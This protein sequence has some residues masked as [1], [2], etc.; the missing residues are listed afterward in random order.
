MTHNLA[1]PIRSDRP[2]FG[3]GVAFALLVG[4]AHL[5]ADWPQFRGPEGTG[6]TETR[7]VPL[8][9]SET[10]NVT[11]RTA[12]HG[13][14]W[15]SPV[16][17]GTPVWLTTATED[18]RK[19]SALAVDRET[20]KILHDLPLFDVATPQYAHPF[21]TYASPSPAI[22]PGRVYVTFGSPGTAALD[23]TT[24]KV[25]WQRR[26]FVCNHF[27]GAGSSPVI[28]GNLLLMHFD[29]S[30][31]QFVV[32]LDKRSGTTVWRTERSVDFK[33]IGPD[34]KI[35]AEGD[36]R[37]AFSTPRVITVDGRP[38]MISIG[39]KA[40]YGYELATGKEL[41]RIEEPTNHS[42][43][44]VP[45]V[46]DGLVYYQ[47]G[48]PRGELLAVRP[49]G[50]GNATA[51]HVVWRLARSVPNKPSILLKDGLIYMVGDAGIAS[52]V[53]AKTGQVVWSSR[54]AGSYSASPVSADGR[55]YFFSEEGKTTV[56]AAGRE[57]KVLAENQLGDGFM[58]T[59]ALAGRSLF[60][61]SRTHLYRI[62]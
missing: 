22:E 16:V 60:L 52:A 14:A 38:V 2:C 58:A 13:R 29:G 41:W 31:H 6:I 34:G 8:T 26:D 17:L 10:S 32:A 53:D 18:G 9:W 45:A 62:D 40:V 46:G 5:A 28:A 4:G 24:G 23:T 15:S 51:T 37:K 19:L 48:F 3:F 1:M 49:N 33:D 36:F 54:V 21:N 50:T 56:I 44:T 42:A 43:S 35:Q 55:V 61:R 20:G 25:L 12:V 11:W 30:D 59:P 47:S 27:R 57:F 39:S 7:G